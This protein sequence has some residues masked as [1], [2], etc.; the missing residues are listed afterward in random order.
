MIWRYDS[1]IFTAWLW[2]YSETIRKCARSWSSV[3]GLMEDHPN[4][5]FACSQ[6]SFLS[7]Q[8]IQLCLNSAVCIV[9]CCNVNLFVLSNEYH[10]DTYM[11]DKLQYSNATEIDYTSNICLNFSLGPT[12]GMGKAALPW[13]LCPH[14]AKYSTGSISACWWHLGGNG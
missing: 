5:T 1:Y 7:L 14:K 8:L 3:L 11:I 4:M 12:A 13:S 10:Y 9:H 2:P 6:V